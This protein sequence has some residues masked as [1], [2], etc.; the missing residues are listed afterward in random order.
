VAGAA[1]ERRVLIIGAA[2]RDFHINVAFRVAPSCE[3][4][5]FTSA[6]IPGTS[7]DGAKLT[8]G[9][10]AYGAGYVADGSRRSAALK[11]R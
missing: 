3:V 6:Q 2:G 11:S 9:G 10:M 4:V 8:R 5:A 1:K 7:S